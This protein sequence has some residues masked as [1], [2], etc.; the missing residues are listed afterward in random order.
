MSEQLQITNNWVT[1]ESTDCM[2][3][4]NNEYRDSRD[5]HVANKDSAI[6]A[7]GGDCGT[8]SDSD[9]ETDRRKR[10]KSKHKSKSKRRRHKSSSSS[11]SSESTDSSDSEDDRKRRKKKSKKRK[12]RSSSSSSSSSDSSDSSE[13]EK[14]KKKRKKRSKKKKSKKHKKDKKSSDSKRKAK[15]SNEEKKKVKE[16]PEVEFVTVMSVGNLPIELKW[17]KNLIKFTI[18][19]PILQH[20]INPKVNI[21]PDDFKHSAVFD[22]RNNCENESKEK[23][24]SEYEKFI[25]E[26][27]PV[28]GV[29]NNDDSHEM[30]IKLREKLV[31]QLNDKRSHQ[32]HD[33][34]RRNSDK[35]KSDLIDDHRRRDDRSPNAQRSP[36]HRSHKSEKHDSRSNK[37]HERDSLHKTN[38]SISDR[39]HSYH[40]FD[41][42]HSKDY[43]NT[44]DKNL[45][46]KKRT[47]RELL[48]KV[49]QKKDLN[50]EKEDKT[51]S[52]EISSH[53]SKGLPQTGKIPEKKKWLS[54]TKTATTTTT[55]NADSS[56]STYVSQPMKLNMNFD[57]NWYYNYYYNSLYG[58]AQYPQT[59]DPTLASAYYAQYSMATSY[60]YSQTDLTNWVSERGYSI[61]TPHN[62]QQIES[63]TKENNENNIQNGE[64]TILTGVV[65]DV[66]E[67]NSTLISDITIK[68]ETTDTDSHKKEIMKES[69][70]T[71]SGQ[72]IETLVSTIYP[73]ITFDELTAETKSENQL[74]LT[75]ISSLLNPKVNVRETDNSIDNEMS[76]PNSPPPPPALPP[77]PQIK[78]M[79]SSESITLPNGEVLPPGT[80]QI[81]VPPYVHPNQSED[82]TKFTAD[83][84]YNAFNGQNTAQTNV[85]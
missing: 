54:K 2:D 26:L 6:D 73:D 49:K 16:E 69:D 62:E 20:S 27:N 85:S 28:S 48:E 68:E 78:T 42:K 45:D 60:D 61:E 17:P 84:Y 52:K 46:D 39:S 24:N 67:N 55:A 47:A 19:E 34:D 74:E 43:S 82:P 25:G 63:N 12:H 9:S 10:K 36:S 79:I 71:N 22:K 56:Q 30:E 37:S 53:K 3:T 81:I 70:E 5:K 35:K 13:S 72:K 32:N 14:E 83:W 4:T 66:I 29:S 51:K 58:M 77:R 8:K 64:Q 59:N 44:S 18:T 75:P 50:K 57:Y 33:S 7:N 80:K 15:V 65:S 21:N 40:S 1:V 38:N 23:L 31:K 11:S 41:K 76:E